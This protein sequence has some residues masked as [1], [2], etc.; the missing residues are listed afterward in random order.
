MDCIH[1]VKID[2]ISTSPT[3]GQWTV[4]PHIAW[5][6]LNRI[7]RWRRSDW[8]NTASM[9]FRFERI[10]DAMAFKLRWCE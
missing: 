5:L 9:T 6:K 10:E 3:Y 2:G 4:E 7:S 1:F 8:Q